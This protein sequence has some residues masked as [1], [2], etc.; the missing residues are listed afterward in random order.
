MVSHAGLAFCERNA[1]VRHSDENENYVVYGTIRVCPE[2]VAGAGWITYYVSD[3]P[4]MKA[5]I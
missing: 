5:L 1:K 3:I 2:G 4:T